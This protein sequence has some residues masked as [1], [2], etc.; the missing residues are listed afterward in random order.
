MVEN[1]SAIRA[2]ILYGLYRDPFVVSQL[3]SKRRVLSEA[4][5]ENRVL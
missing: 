1:F 5:L 2:F 4:N 3:T